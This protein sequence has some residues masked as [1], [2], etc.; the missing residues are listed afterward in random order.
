MA[1]TDNLIDFLKPSSDSTES[2]YKQLSRSL[3]NAIQDGLLSP[4]DAL[5]P[6]RDL[7]TRLKM[8]RITVR[9]AIDQLVEIGLLVKRQGAGTVV[10][11]NVDLV[12]HKNLF[13]FKQFYSGYEK[14]GVLESYSR[15][16]SKGRGKGFT[17]GGL[18]SEFK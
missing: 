11:E 17:E 14:R 16:V 15:V 6:E 18:N 12:L 9:K 1:T 13:I 5:I 8:S 7:A 3:N 2:L 10:S 4:G